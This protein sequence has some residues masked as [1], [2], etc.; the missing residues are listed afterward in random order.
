MIRPRISILRSGEMF[1]SREG[2]GREGAWE[3]WEAALPGGGLR[4]DAGVDF[5]PV[6][7]VRE[8]AFGR[9]IGMT[10]SLYCQK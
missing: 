10:E 9:L 1:P 5:L 6:E 3:G 4:P 2:A 7:W 8:E